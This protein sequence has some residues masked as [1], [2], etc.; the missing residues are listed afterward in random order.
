MS[1][2][3]YENYSETSAT[4]DQ[5]RVPIGVDAILAGLRAGGLEPAQVRLLDAG[6][7]T[8]SYLLAL[9]QHL[10]RL[11][12]LEV[13]TGML[14]RA[15]AKLAA[16]GNVVLQHGSVLAMP[17][18]DA[19]F[20]AVLFNQVIHHLDTPDDGSWP[21]LGRALA[22]SH[23]VLLPGG[24]LIINT[25]SQQQLPE[26]SWYNALIPDAAAR[27]ARRYVPI[28]T[29][30][31]MLDQLGFD[32]R[33]PHVIREPFSADRYFDAAGPFDKS[34]RNGDSIWALTTEPELEAAL[35]TL[36]AQHDA[37]TADAFV[38]KHDRSRK[39]I[40]HALILHA[41]RR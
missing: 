17:F 29:L 18:A 32:V 5:I 12:G 35:T 10:G 4:Y 41:W 6:C 13:S 33:E 40:G 20:D 22:E 24:A 14:D 16:C 11:A 7:G 15:R 34:W 37:G 19:H 38:Q 21:N 25:C 31:V 23:R 30:V 1:Q 36:R 8:G 3:T 27:L 9:S 28:D 26:C 2:S 39:A